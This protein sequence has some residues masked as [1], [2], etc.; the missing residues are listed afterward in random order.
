MTS[1]ATRVEEATLPR[2]AL[3]TTAN[4]VRPLVVPGRLWQA[5]VVAGDL[6]ALVAI[7]F[8]IPFVILAI[9]LPIVLCARLL[10]WLVGLL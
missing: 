6:L 2:V 5:T 7:V 10:S 3:A 9:T 1:A 4:Q 8:C